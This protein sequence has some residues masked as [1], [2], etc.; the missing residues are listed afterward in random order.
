VLS[1]CAIVAREFELPAV[2][3]TQVGT[4]EIPDGATVEVNGTKGTVTILDGLDA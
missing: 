1:H 4:I 3:G 2:V